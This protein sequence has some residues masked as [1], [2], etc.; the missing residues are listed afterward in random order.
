MYIEKNL[1]NGI[2]VIAEKIDYLRSV[3][4]GV[5]VGNGSRHEAESENGMSHFIEH[6]LFKGSSKRSAAQIASAIDSVGGELNAFTARE[7][8]CFYTRTLDAHAELAV[9]VLSD[10]LIRPTLSERDMDMERRVVMEEI[11]MDDDSPAALADN[12][13]YSTVWRGTSAGRPILGTPESLS[14]ITPDKMRGYMRTHYT[15]R[16]I[17]IAVSGSFDDSL[18]DMLERYFGCYDVKSEPPELPQASFTHGH[19]FREKD[20]EQVQLIAGFNGIDIMDEAVYPLLVFNNVFGDGMSSRLFQNIREREGLVY[21][22]FA[23]HGALTGTGT[24]DIMAE[25]SAE[26]FERVCEL[27]DRE[28][29]TVRRDGLTADEVERAKEMLKGRYMLSYESTSQRMESAGRSLL[30]NKRVYS[31]EEVIRKID[32]VNTSSIADIIER[33]FGNGAAATAVLGPVSSAEAAH[34]INM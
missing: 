16:N 18:F 29:R 24:F 12:M 32:E 21:S 20:I 7:Y 17:V 13:Y 11:R 6:M 26:N 8:T 25:M 10:M 14:G 34:G 15:A 9:D 19:A 5:W 1:S 33:L 31:P 23:S 4:I 22:V 28:I 3:S 30:A 27:I 2:R